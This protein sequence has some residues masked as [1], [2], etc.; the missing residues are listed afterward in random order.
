MPEK[1]L[2][3]KQQLVRGIQVIGVFVD[4]IPER[5]IELLNN[6]LIDSVQLHG[7]EDE[8]YIKQLKQLTDKPIIKAFRIETARDIMR[9]K[10]CIA[11]YIMLDSGAGTG[12][13]FDWKLI[14]CIERP[15]FL[16]GGLSSNN[17][18]DAVRLL[19]PFAVDVS[20]GI[21]THEVKDKTKMAAFVAS[22]REEKGL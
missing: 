9:A 10:H 12:E 3:L 6:G 17:V 8:D 1:A 20:S 7:N 2:E 14:Q 22:V 11:D 18:N 5:I 4:E 16:A 13:V 15:Y 19:H 21:E